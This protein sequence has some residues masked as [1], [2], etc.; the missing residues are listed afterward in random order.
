[1]VLLYLA[2]GVLTSFVFYNIIHDA[3]TAFLLANADLLYGKNGEADIY[4]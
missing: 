3:Y 1:M 4:G 2:E